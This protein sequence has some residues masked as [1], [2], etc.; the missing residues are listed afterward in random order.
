MGPP[1]LLAF[2]E[3]A[4]NSSLRLTKESLE[5]IVNNVDEDGDGLVRNKG[6]DGWRDRHSKRHSVYILYGIFLSRCSRRILELT[7]VGPEAA[8]NKREFVTVRRRRL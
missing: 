5:T 1:Q 8:A 7:A 4:T 3:R 6:T 2:F